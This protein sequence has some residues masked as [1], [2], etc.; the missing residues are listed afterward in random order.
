LARATAQPAALCG[1]GAGPGSAISAVFVK[2]TNLSLGGPSVMLRALVALALTNTLQ[3]LMQGA[4]LAWKEPTP[5]RRALATWRSGAWVGTLSACGS[6]CWFTAFALAPIA[7]V[8]SVGHVE[9]VFTLSFSRFYLRERLRRSDVAGLGLN[10][11]GVLLIV[12]AQR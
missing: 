11:A 4:W 7:L 2:L 10:V 12:A 8:R 3:T 6:A 5:L 1:F 9:I